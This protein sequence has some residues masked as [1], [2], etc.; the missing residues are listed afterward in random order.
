V[1][2]TRRKVPALL[3]GLVLITAVL[4]ATAVSA[5]RSAPQTRAVAARGCLGYCKHPT[6]AAKV[7]RWGG[8]AWDQEFVSRP[9]SSHWKSNHRRAVGQQHGMLT[10]QAG[11]HTGTIK[12]WPDNQSARTGRWEARI[13]AYDSGS[14][15]RY[16]VTW[17]LVP[18]HGDDRC[19]ANAIVLAKYRPGDRRVTGSVRTPPGTSFTYS[20]ARDLRD[21]AWH[22]YAVEITKR[23]VS[24][25]V[26]TQVVRTEK[27]PAALSGVRYRPQLVMQAEHGATMRQS[28]MQSDWVRYYTLHRPDARSIK[29]P[30]MHRAAYLHGC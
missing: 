21:R 20:R 24:W 11:R 14:G 23:H 6:N 8:P 18:A 7:F 12:V 28:W 22:T 3:G 13:R 29:A 17:E 5:P 2:P 27:R 15:N 1:P 30:P 26:D 25:F 4:V 9:F 19:G 10:I 16:H